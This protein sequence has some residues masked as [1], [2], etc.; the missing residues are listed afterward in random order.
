MIYLTSILFQNLRSHWK[1]SW[2]SQLNSSSDLK[3]KSDILSLWKS[4]V[5]VK[6]NMTHFQMREFVSSATNLDSFKKEENSILK[7]K[8]LEVLNEILCY[9]STLGI[10][11]DVP[12]EV[13]EVAHQIVRMSI[14]DGIDF[15]ISEVHIGLAGKQSCNR[16][17]IF[18]CDGQVI[19]E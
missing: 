9:G 14:T 13:S 2:M 18:S 10:Q 16:F 4:L 19:S 3:F 7:R 11:S 12:G 5:D 17:L 6:F 1:L 15:K 8:W